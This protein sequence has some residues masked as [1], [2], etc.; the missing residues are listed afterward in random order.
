[1]HQS[2][3]KYNFHS[4]FDIYLSSVTKLELSSTISIQILFSFLLNAN[5]ILSKY[6]IFSQ[7]ISFLCIP[8]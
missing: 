8:C 6:A 5:E 3:G 2:T 4:N 1:M 7:L